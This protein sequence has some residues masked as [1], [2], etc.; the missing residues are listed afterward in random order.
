[1]DTVHQDIRPKT[2]ICDIDGL[3]FRHCG[4]INTQHLSKPV[5]LAGVKEKFKEWDRK[6][7]NIILMTGRRESTR[8]YTEKQ[9]TESGI[10]FDQLVMGVGGG[11]RVLINDRKEKGSGN[12]AVAINVVRNVE[13]LSN[14]DV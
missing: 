1:M 11:V 5:L 4:D 8:E 9:L 3:L 10:F 13:G 14:V 2:I 6:G 7:Y 12:T